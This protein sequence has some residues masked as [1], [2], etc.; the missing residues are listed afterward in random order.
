MPTTSRPAVIAELRRRLGFLV[1]E[2]GRPVCRVLPFEV[3]ALDAHLPDG[4]LAS[5]ALHEIGVRGDNAGDFAA[6]S[7]FVAGVLARRA[8][9]ILWCRVAPDLFAPRLADAGLAADRVLCTEV[10]DERTVVAA[11]EEGLRCGGLAGVVG[12]VGRLPLPAGRRLQRAAADSGALALVLRRGD[13][14]GAA[15]AIGDQPT[16]A[17]TC[18]RIAVLPSRGRPIVGLERDRW[19]V[20]LVRCRGGEPASWTLEACDGQG[21]LAVPA[22]LAVEPSDEGGF[23]AEEDLSAEPAAAAVDGEVPGWPEPAWPETYRARA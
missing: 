16:A 4:G 12:E 15:A 6:A 1:H 21:R 20:K 5:G 18:W 19:R 14:G 7:L 22:E 11:M 8:G 2:T 17:V 23:Y 9:P 10:G 13:R 3:P